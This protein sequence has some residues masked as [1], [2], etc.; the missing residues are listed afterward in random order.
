MLN[1]DVSNYFSYNDVTSRH[2]IRPVIILKKSAI[3]STCPTH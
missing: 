2:Y 3:E 1:N